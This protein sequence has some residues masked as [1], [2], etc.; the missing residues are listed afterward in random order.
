MEG[1]GGCTGREHRS[2]TSLSLHLDLCVASTW[3]LRAIAFII[4]W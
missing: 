3:L 1:A 2:S 4:N